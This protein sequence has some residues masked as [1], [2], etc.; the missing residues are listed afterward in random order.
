MDWKQ[1]LHKM[2]LC[3]RL[4]VYYA[5][6]SLTNSWSFWLVWTGW[7]NVIFNDVPF[8]QAR[9]IHKPYVPSFTVVVFI[10]LFWWGCVPNWQSLTVYRDRRFGVLSY[11]YFA[12]NHPWAQLALL[13]LFYVK[14]IGV[15]TWTAPFLGF[16]RVRLCRWAE[17]LRIRQ[18][19]GSTDGTSSSCW[20]FI[21][22]SGRTIETKPINSKEKAE[23]RRMNKWV[24]V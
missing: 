5:P 10:T 16:C 11:Q 13:L 1:T 6:H 7:K 22:Q 9:S 15:F 24:V 18:R 19:W 4:N 20:C 14:E 2:V 8:F 3:A 21:F 17:K 23:K 12:L